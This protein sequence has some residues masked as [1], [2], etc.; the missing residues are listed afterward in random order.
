MEKAKKKPQSVKKDIASAKI[1]LPKEEN[2]SQLQ[3]D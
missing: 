2:S 3:V 1:E